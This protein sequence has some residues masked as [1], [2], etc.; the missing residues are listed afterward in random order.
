M[1]EHDD[2][3]YPKPSLVKQ[4]R[5]YWKRALTIDLDILNIY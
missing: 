5:Y 2:E 1:S 3:K 4:E